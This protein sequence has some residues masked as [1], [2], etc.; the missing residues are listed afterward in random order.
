MKAA[1]AISDKGRTTL[2]RL[3]SGCL[4]KLARCPKLDTFAL[5]LADEPAHD[6]WRE[7][8]PIAVMPAAL[9]RTK[10]ASNVALGGGGGC[11]HPQLVRGEALHVVE[12]FKLFAPF[13]PINKH[14]I[15]TSARPAADEDDQSYV[16]LLLHGL[17]LYISLLMSAQTH[18][19]LRNRLIC[20]A[21]LCSEFVR[22]VLHLECTHKHSRGDT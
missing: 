11:E 12:Q 3:S 7:L 19:P 9:V 6:G 13:D 5:D 18:M 2:L 10:E 22:R 20:G 16:A 14:Q 8:E 1:L 17:A 4:S 15:T 21:C